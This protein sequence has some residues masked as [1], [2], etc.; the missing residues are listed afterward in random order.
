MYACIYVHTVFAR[1]NQSSQSSCCGA[2]APLKMRPPT[3]K[4]IHI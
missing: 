4:P 3:G 2:A 1:T